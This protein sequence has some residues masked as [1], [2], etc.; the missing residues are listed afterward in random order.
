MY[1]LY[2]VAKTLLDDTQF[3][4]CLSN[5]ILRTNL[6]AAAATVTEL[7]KRQ[8]SITDDDNSFK[9][10]DVT[11]FSALVALALINLGNRGVDGFGMVECRLDKEVGIGLLYITVEQHN[12]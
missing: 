7:G 10:A 2:S 5:G 4:A 9:L 1:Q 3:P 8:N 11:S 6:N 12:I